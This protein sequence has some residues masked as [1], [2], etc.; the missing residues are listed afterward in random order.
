MKHWLRGLMVVLG[1]LFSFNGKSTEVP[2]NT[3]KILRLRSKVMTFNDYR[4]GF[5][6]VDV[7]ALNGLNFYTRLF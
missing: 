7:I 3:S 1:V 5:T 6:L 2:R 4:K